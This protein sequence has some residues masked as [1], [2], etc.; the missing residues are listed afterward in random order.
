[1]PNFLTTN[2]FKLLK[3][4]FGI[5]DQLK[6]NKTIILIGKSTASSILILLAD[7]RVVNV[8]ITIIIMIL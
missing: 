5:Y 6:I 1:M 3:F 2:F 7:Y 8:F 4:F